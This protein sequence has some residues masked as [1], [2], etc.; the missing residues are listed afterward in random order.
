MVETQG[1]EFAYP[2]LRWILKGWFF[3]S[4][5]IFLYLFW[6]D[7]FVHRWFILLWALFSLGLGAYVAPAIRIGREWLGVKYLWS[8]RRIPWSRVV[9]VQRTVFGAQIMT[10]ELNWAYRV[11]GYQYPMPHVNE[12]VTAIRRGMHRRPGDA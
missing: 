4:A 11:V 12:L 2:L 7:V 9:D 10:A 1:A 8:Y 6:I 5:I 3:L